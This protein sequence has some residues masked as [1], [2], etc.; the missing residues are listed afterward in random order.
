MSMEYLSISDVFSS[1]FNVL[2]FFLLYKSFSCLD[3][4]QPQ[5]CRETLYQKKKKG[6]KKEG[7]KE[8]RK[9][10]REKR[11]TKEGREREGRK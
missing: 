11:R 1:F 6:K 9:E 3:P 4:G 10:K 7:G 8:E 2:K 5:L